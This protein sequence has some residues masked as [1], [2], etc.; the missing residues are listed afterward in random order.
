[1]SAPSLQ[2]E[3]DQFAYGA[4]TPAASWSAK[5][6]YFF[7]WLFVFVIPAD[8]QIAPAPY[9][10][11][12]CAGL[13]GL[14]GVMIAGRVRR[15]SAA[16]LPLVALL[17]WSAATYFWSAEP[18]ITAARIATYA[19]LTIL[20]WLIWQ[21]ASSPIRQT[22]LARAYVLGTFLPSAATILNYLHGKVALTETLGGSETLRYTAG[23]FN[24]N[25]LGLLLAISL[26]LSIYL[27]A[28]SKNM[29]MRCVYGLQSAAALVAIILTSS[30]A[31]FA[32]AM[33]ALILSPAMLPAVRVMR[34]I[35]SLGALAALFAAGALA[36]PQ[37]SWQ[38]LSTTLSEATDGTMHRRTQIWSAAL[39][40]YTAR[41]FSGVGAAALPSV[42]TPMIGAGAVAH[43]TYLSILVELGAIGAVLALLVGLAGAACLR[44]LPLLERRCWMVAL[45]VWSVGVAT[46]SWEHHK[47]TWFLFGLL[48]AQAGTLRPG[49]ATLIR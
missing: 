24:E 37:G 44:A 48:V 47:P 2:H 18:D 27:N 17:A 19:Q 42:L 11:G 46:L 9:F 30:R 6:A 15:P 20:V 31:A 35:R 10:I 8:E 13:A 32:A 4:S 12:V 36:M 29:P 3:S 34:K 16:H 14:L 38:R 40:V 1:M 5:A 28:G 39:E 49:S 33:L 45:L 22:Q 43:N 7:L 25:D 26:P 41:P 23:T 21:Y